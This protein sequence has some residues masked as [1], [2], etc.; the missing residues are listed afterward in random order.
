MA[1]SIHGTPGPRHSFQSTMHGQPVWIEPKLVCTV[2]YLMKNASGSLRQP[3]FKGLP[4][5][6]APGEMPGNFG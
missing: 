1:V 6:Q 3:V 2:K 4:Q 5:G